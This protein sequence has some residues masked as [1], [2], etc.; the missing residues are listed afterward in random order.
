[1]LCRFTSAAI[2]FYSINLIVVVFIYLFTNQKYMDSFCRHIEMFSLPLY[3]LLLFYS[4][5]FYSNFMVVG[6]FLFFFIYIP[7]VNEFC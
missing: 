3:C 5:L 6:F 1:M 2:L 4:I 7:F